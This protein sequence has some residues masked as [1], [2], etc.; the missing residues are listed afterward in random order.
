LVVFVVSFCCGE[1]L[2]EL[3]FGSEVVK[4]LL[5]TLAPVGEFGGVS[6][7]VVSGGAVTGLGCGVGFRVVGFGLAGT[8]GD[9]FAL[10]AGTGL[11]V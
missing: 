3:L 5:M 7:G 10:F 6:Y 8:G 1:L 2:A 4:L 11:L 9:A